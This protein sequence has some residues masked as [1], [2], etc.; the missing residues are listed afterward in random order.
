MMKK[1]L[2]GTWKVVESV[3]IKILTKAISK[4]YGWE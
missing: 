2:Q 1:S 3:A 4:Y